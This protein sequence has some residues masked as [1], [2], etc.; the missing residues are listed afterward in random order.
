M[1]RQRKALLTR[2]RRRNF[3]HKN[4][5]SDNASSI[6]QSTNHLFVFLLPSRSLIPFSF[7][8]ENNAGY[9]SGGGIKLRFVYHQLTFS[10]VPRRHST[11]RTP[12]QEQSVGEASPLRVS[13]YHR[14]QHAD[15]NCQSVL[16]GFSEATEPLRRTDEWELIKDASVGRKA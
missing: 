6:D 15:F 8:G 1:L 7:G 9:H 11:A 4:R 12:E 2:S 16:I 14:H 5:I 10:K 3:N 13:G